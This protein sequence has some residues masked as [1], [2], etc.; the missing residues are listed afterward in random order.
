MVTS[1]C[2]SVVPRFFALGGYIFSVM[3][4]RIGDIGFSAPFRY[5]SLLWALLIG[6]VVFGEWPDRLTLLGA[7]IVVATGLFSLYR[8]RVATRRT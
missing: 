1:C 8:E 6:F 2:W 7:S 3:V 4:M 5:T